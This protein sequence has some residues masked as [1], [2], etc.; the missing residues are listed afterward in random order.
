MEKENHGPKSGEGRRTIPVV[1]QRRIPTVP[2]EREGIGGFLG[3]VPNQSTTGFDSHAGE[4]MASPSVF[5]IYWGRDY[6][7]PGAGLNAKASSMDSF[8]TMVM[9]SR[10]LDMLSQYSVGRGVFLGSTWLDHQPGLPLSLTMNQMRDVLIGWIDIGLSPKVPAW[11]ERD[12]L[13]IIFPPTEITLTDND[14]GTGF[15][16]YHWYGHYRNSP[17]QKDNL[18]FA[19]VDTTGDSA[20]V[21]HELAEAF[22]DRSLNGWYSDDAPYS[23]IADTCSSC[24]SQALILNGFSIASYWLAR[25]G[26]CLQQTDVVPGPLTAVPNLLGERAETARQKIEAAGFLLHQQLTVDHT[27]ESIGRIITQAPRGGTEVPQGSSVSIWIGTR[28]PH[29]CPPGDFR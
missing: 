13:F 8:L 26:R 6:G 15:C 2:I 18:F 17:F 11:D 5:A 22:T 27:C 19:V 21:G 20:T 16:G 10:Y 23:E 29:E 7:T 25:E 12:L 24:G 28:P 1:I 4:V 14:G 9:Q 3:P